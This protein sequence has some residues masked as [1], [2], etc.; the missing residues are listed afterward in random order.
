MRVAK[1]VRR[2]ASRTRVAG[3]TDSSGPVAFNQRLSL[4]RA[5]TVKGFL[6]RRGQVAARE[7]FAVGFGERRPLASNATERGRQRTGGWFTF[8][9]GTPFARI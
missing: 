8:R 6:S 1:V 3:Y 5:R 2:A 9:L 4:T 7:M